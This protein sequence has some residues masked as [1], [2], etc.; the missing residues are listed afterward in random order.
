M[1]NGE[2]RIKYVSRIVLMN[3]QVAC[4]KSNIGVGS[5]RLVKSYINLAPSSLYV[6][7]MFS[8]LLA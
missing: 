6:L 8:R 5:L 7:L 2:V 1:N 4:K 3:S